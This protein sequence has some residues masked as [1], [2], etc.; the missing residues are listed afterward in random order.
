MYGDYRWM[1]PDGPSATPELVA[2][3][4]S[5]ERL[6]PLVVHRRDLPACLAAGLKAQTLPVGGPL[7]GTVWVGEVRHEC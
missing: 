2:A 3:W 6:G 1:A 5:R 4:A 7:P